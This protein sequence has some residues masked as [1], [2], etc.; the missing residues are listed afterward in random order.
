MTTAIILVPHP[1]PFRD[2]LRSSQDHPTI[3]V[4]GFAWGG[5]GSGVNRVDVSSDGGQTFTRAELLAKPVQQRRG[6]EWSW[7]LF[8]KVR[9][10]E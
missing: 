8:E 5:G 2:S 7:Q 9:S 3:K 1:S 4:K 6:A 10:D